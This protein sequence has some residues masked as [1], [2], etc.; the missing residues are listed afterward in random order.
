MNMKKMKKSVLG[1]LANKVREDGR[2]PVCGSESIGFCI[3]TKTG[4]CDKGHEWK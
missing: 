4:D 2:C 3:P 1:E